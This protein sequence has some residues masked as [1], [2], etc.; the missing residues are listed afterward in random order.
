[1]ANFPL[2]LRFKCA[3]GSYG[4]RA[5]ADTTEQACGFLAQWR[6]Q[7]FTEFDIEDATGQSVSEADL[8]APRPQG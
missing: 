6:A 1:M 7:G 2:L 8:N 3:D 4:A 5:H